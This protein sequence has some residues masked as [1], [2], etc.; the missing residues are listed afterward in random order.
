MRKPCTRLI[1]TSSCVVASLVLCACGATPSEPGD[2]EIPR[3]SLVVTQV[4]AGGSHSCAIDASGHAYCWGWNNRGQLGDG[5]TTDRAF[6]VEVNGGLIFVRL[7]AG[8]EHT[9]GLTTAGETYCWGRDIAL[10][11]G[12]GTS[13]SLEPSPVS[14]DLTLVTVVA[15]A[16]HSCGLTGNGQAYC[17]GERPGRSGH[18]PVPVQVPG[19]YSFTS[20][21]AGGGRHTCGLTAERPVCWGPNGRGQLGNGE[22]GDINDREDIP[23]EVETNGAQFIALSAGGLHSCALTIAGE[24]MCWGFNGSGQIGDGTQ[25][26]HLVPVAV[27]GGVRFN[28]IAAGMNQTCGLAKD[29]TLYCWLGIPAQLSPELKF[30]SVASGGQHSCAVALSGAAYC[31]GANFAGQLG[32]GTTEQRLEPDLVRRR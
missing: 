13:D 21:T 16:F 2:D 30:E 14:G 27:A 6:P 22:G 18:N 26:R 23:V 31:W 25:A 32:D 11:D 10:G 29:D 15:G 19:D 1:G 24:A 17:W 5:T 12:Q 9:C 8:A 28:S 3:D 7:A 4:T 20:I